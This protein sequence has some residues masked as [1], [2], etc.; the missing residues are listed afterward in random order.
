MLTIVGGPM[1]SGKTTWLINYIEKLTPGSFVLFKPDIDTRFGKN[2]CMTHHG[3]SYPATN[4]STKKPEFPPMSNTITNI[5]ID[6]LNFFTLEN[7]FDELKEQQKRG[8]NIVASGL[9]LDYRKQPF[10]ATL[11]LSK[12]ADTFIQLYAI[13]DLCKKDAIHSYRKVHEK[14]QF[15]LGAKES[16]GACCDLCWSKMNKN[17]PS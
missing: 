8:R 13:C 10:G 2:V 3:K 16:Y 6:E 15:L 11:P 9:L 12:I 1:F 17:L 4:L 14:K 7:L 5:L